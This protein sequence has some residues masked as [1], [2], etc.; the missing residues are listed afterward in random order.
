MSDIVINNS[1][2]W[3][4]RQKTVKDR[5]RKQKRI[6]NRSTWYKM[7][8][9][10]NWRLYITKN[11]RLKRR[12]KRDDLDN[13]FYRRDF[14]KH[15]YERSGHKCEICGKEIAWEQNELHHILPLH[16][17]P[18]FAMDERNMQC[19]CHSCHKGIHCDPYK[20]IRQMEQKSKELNINLKDYYD[21]CK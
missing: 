21:V 20:T 15:C 5:L 18:Q 1:N 13:T 17:F 6:E 16:R 7:F 8:Q 2:V 14:R 11:I 10:G 4:T 19:L 12:N 3:I 9:L